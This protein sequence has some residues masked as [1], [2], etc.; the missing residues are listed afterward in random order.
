MY[1]YHLTIESRA[2]DFGFDPG[3]TED[4]SLV[5]NFQYVYDLQMESRPTDGLL[6]MG[7][8]EY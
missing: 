3:S 5:P 7:A 2:I 1:D 4:I 8:F 6:D